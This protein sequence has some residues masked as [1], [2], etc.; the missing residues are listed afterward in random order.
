MTDHPTPAEYTDYTLGAPVS[1]TKAPGGPIAER[2]NTRRFEVKLVNPANK[3]KHT[4]H[5]RRHRPG[6]RRRPRRRWP[7]SATRSSSSA[8][9]TRPRRAHSHRRAGRDQRRQE[10]PERRR[11]RLPAVLR[12][13]QGR[14][15]PRPRGQRLSPRPDQRR[16]SSTSASPRACRSPASTAAC[17]T[18]AP[19]AAPRSRAPSTRAARPASSCCSAPTRRCCGR[20]RRAGSRCTPAPRCSTWSWSTAAPA[21]SSP[22]TWSPARSRPT[23]PTPSCSPPAATATSSTSRPTPRAATSPPIWRAHRRG[24]LLRQPRASRR[25]TRPASRVS[26]DHQSK[27]TLMSESLRNDGRIWVPQPSGDDRAAPT[28]IP[29]AERD[30]YLERDLPRASATSCRAT[31]PPGPPRTVR[32]GPRRRPGGLR[33]LPRLRRRDPAGWAGRRSRSS[34]ATCSRC[35]SGSPP[36]TRTRSRCG[37]TRPSTT[38][39]AACG[40]TTTCRAPSPACSCSARPTSPTTAPTAW[41]PAR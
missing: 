32:R 12:H 7:S 17:S 10:L 20:S 4:G 25:S 3:R 37:S 27:L 29:E 6:R 35:T 31:S 18:T 24:A 19:S 9:R 15:L 38:R 13:G 11:Q 36:R 34:T 16:T 26:G 2:W 1:D 30:Y 8:T 28:E 23:S 22:A 33:R 14:R 40:S 41:A 21:A 5:R 39:W